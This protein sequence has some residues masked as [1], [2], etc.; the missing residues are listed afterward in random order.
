MRKFIWAAL[1]G[2]A[3]G[4]IFGHGTLVGCPYAGC[5]TTGCWKSAAGNCWILEPGCFAPGPVVPS[6]NLYYSAPG[7]GTLTTISGQAKEWPTTCAEDCAENTNQDRRTSPRLEMRGPPNCGVQGKPPCDCVPGFGS[8]T[9][10]NC[11][12]CST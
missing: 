2:V 9:N 4:A 11:A 8:Y 12:V 7:T 3:L 1:F 10:V 5:H 6:K